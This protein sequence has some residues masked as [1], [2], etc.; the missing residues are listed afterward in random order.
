MVLDIL[1]CLH[2][3]FGLVHIVITFP[4]VGFEK[5]F[6]VCVGAVGYEESFLAI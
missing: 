2:L 6:S 1:F 4:F 3:F 5:M